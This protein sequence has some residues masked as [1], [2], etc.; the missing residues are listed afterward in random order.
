[1][2]WWRVVVLLVLVVAA[3]LPA[4]AT[5]IIFGGAIA[6]ATPGNPLG[7]TTSS[8]VWASI[9]FD[10][11]LLSGIGPEAL[12][13]GGN[14]LAMADSTLAVNI[15]IGSFTATTTDESFYDQFP[16]IGFV[17]G[18][19]DYVTFFWENFDPCGGSPCSFHWYDP[20]FLP[21]PIDKLEFVFFQDVAGVPTE[22]VRGSF[23]AIP[24]PE[25][26]LLIGAGLAGFGLWRRIGKRR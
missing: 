25:T 16:E 19:L 24:E 4:P 26:A 17:D 21:G 18:Q 9:T 11:T 6:T 5:T 8:P 15:Q 14:S 2:N 20:L 13:P 7:L 10:A 12:S 22:I 1:M 23:Q 3:A